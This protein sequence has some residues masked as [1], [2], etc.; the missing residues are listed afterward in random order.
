MNYS[1]IVIIW[2]KQRNWIIPQPI[3]TQTTKQF[4]YYFFLIQQP[5]QTAWNIEK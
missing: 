2:V 5:N 1:L 3:S 4:P